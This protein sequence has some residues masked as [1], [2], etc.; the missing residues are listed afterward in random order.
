MNHLNSVILT[1][2]VGGKCFVVIVVVVM[3][4]DIL[5]FQHRPIIVAKSSMRGRREKNL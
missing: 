3:I 5:V 1:F 4:T 2:Q